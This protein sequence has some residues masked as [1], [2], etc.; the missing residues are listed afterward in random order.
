MSQVSAGLPEEYSNTAQEQQVFASL[1]FFY[2]RTAEYQIPGPLQEPAN[3]VSQNRSTRGWE[4]V[5][6][7]LKDRSGETKMQG[8]FQI[9]N[10]GN[11][12]S[13]SAKAGLI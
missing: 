7:Q 1:H 10:V 12:K 5:P 11:Q 8:K 6:S 3:L 9:E 13:K 2:V 4:T